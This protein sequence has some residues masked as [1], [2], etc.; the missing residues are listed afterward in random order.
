M[1]AANGG[2]KHSSIISVVIVFQNVVQ[3]IKEKYNLL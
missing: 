2:S 1:R 3:I